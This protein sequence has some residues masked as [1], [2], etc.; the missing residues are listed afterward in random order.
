MRCLLP[1]CLLFGQCKIMGPTLQSNYLHAAGPSMAILAPQ[2]KPGCSC[3]AKPW[4]AN[5]HLAPS[6]I[7]RNSCLCLSPGQLQ[8][9]AVPRLV[10]EQPLDVGRLLPRSSTLPH[11]TAAH[12]SQ[13]RQ[14]C[15]LACTQTQ[16]EMSRP[17]TETSRA[18]SILCGDSTREATETPAALT[19]TL[20]AICLTPQKS[21]TAREGHEAAVFF[22]FSF[23]LSL[24]FAMSLQILSII[25]SSLL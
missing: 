14:I 22:T 13:L 24:A 1:A 7:S 2:G 23:P 16:Q 11:V 6:L 17:C 9:V 4:G 10:P 5:S 25:T 12:W 18:V 21:V 20:S 15:P 8:S 3:N 19:H